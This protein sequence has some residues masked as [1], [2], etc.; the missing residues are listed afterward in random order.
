MLPAPLAS[1]GSWRADRRKG[2]ALPPRSSCGATC[3]ATT[4]TCAGWAARVACRTRGAGG[5]AGCGRS[6]SPRRFRRL[7]Q[8]ALALTSDRVIEEIARAKPPRRGRRTAGSATS[9]LAGA[10]IGS[11]SAGG[12]NAIAVGRDGGRDHRHGLLLGNP[13]LPW[14]GT[15]RFYQAQLTIPGQLD[16]QGA[17]LYGFP[18]IQIGHTRQVAWSHT[19]PPGLSFTIY[20]LTLA[21]GAPTSYLLDGR[22]VR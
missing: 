17:S 3:R 1:S 13:H 20:R 18:P 5:G 7:F 9:S 16:V 2:R 21:R 11:T 22:R 12:S 14:Q 10:G 6:R 19:T 15:D 8:V 4:P